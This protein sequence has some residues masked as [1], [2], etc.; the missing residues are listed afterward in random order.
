MTDKDIARALDISHHTVSLHIRE[1]MRR[2]GVNSRKAALRR[3]A[4]DPLYASGGMSPSSVSPP[5]HGASDDLGDDAA[6][7]GPEAVARWRL[8]PPPSAPPARLGLILVFAAV[9]ALVTVGLVSV[10][11]GAASQLAYHAPAAALTQ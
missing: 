8:P 9:A 7:M 4:E 5:D 1:A 2:L 3:L 6:D 11:S 10:V